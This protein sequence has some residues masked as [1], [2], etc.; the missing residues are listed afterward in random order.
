MCRW[1]ICRQGARRE[2]EQGV[3]SGVPGSGFRK[4][5][6]EEV[7]KPR[8]VLISYGACCGKGC[9]LASWICDLGFCISIS[10]FFF[11]LLLLFF[12]CYAVRMSVR[13]AMGQWKGRE[14]P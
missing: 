5:G 1:S 13:L 6:G 11:F 9:R 7:P 8:L 12:S 2:K 10:F 3:F 4:D 14:A